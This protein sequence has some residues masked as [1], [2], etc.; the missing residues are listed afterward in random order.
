MELA[1]YFLKV[2]ANFKVDA[3]GA[4]LISVVASGIG[5]GV[6][7]KRKGIGWFQLDLAA[8]IFSAIGQGLVLMLMCGFV[9]GMSNPVI[10]LSIIIYQAITPH[11]IFNGGM[12]FG[13][14]SSKLSKPHLNYLFWGIGCLGIMGAGVLLLW[15]YG[16]ERPWVLTALWVGF[17][18]GHSVM[19]PRKSIVAQQLFYSFKA[20]RH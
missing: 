6:A 2:I 15:V 4:A 16:V 11:Y 5:W 1:V 9:W 18:T 12:G 13:K 8:V 14:E 7:A 10:L 19:T 20:I 17:G 3:Y